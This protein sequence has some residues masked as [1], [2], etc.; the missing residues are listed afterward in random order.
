MGGTNFLCIINFILVQRCGAGTDWEAVMKQIKPFVYTA[1]H[2]ETIGLEIEP[3][4][5]SAQVRAA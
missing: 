1:N 3:I 2:G 5:L 4:G